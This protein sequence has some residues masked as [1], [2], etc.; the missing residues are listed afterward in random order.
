MIFTHV[1]PPELKELDTET[2]NGK[3]FYITPEGKK[4]P[5]VTTVSSFHSAKDIQKWRK[6]VGAE[7]ANKIS[8]QASVRGTAVHKLCEDYINNVEDYTKKH[9]PV[10]IQAFNSIKPILDSNI[11]NV[12]MQ[13]CPLYSDYL[14]VG[15]R[16]DCI[17]E[18]NGKLSVIDFKTSR[19]IK[20]K[21]WIKGYLMQES[22]YCVMFEERT[23][24]P[25]RQIVTVI[26]VDN[27]E[28]QIFVEDRDNHIWDFVDV[29]K[30]FKNYYGN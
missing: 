16:V 7:T 23:K 22:A 27:E 20:K 15:G 3:R 25:I 11:N 17:A 30:Q 21:E 14:Q 28:P 19:K 18:W 4:Y 12:V 13:E 10:N 26:T 1:K 2:K 6:R 5:S 29:R 24:I 9:M 8:T